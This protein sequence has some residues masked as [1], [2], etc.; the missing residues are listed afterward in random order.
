MD[1]YIFMDTVGRNPTF[2][3]EDRIWRGVEQTQVDK[4]SDTVSVTLTIVY[5]R[6]RKIEYS[7]INGLFYLVSESSS[8]ESVSRVDSIQFTIDC[9]VSVGVPWVT[10]VS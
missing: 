3:M 8:E 1:R 5:L 6:N 10:E 4:A 9:A 7:N 2:L